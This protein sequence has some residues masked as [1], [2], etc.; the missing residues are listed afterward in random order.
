MYL[1]TFIVKH[2]CFVV[3]RKGLKQNVGDVHI[4]FAEHSK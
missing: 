2:K 3:P 4:I 1:Y